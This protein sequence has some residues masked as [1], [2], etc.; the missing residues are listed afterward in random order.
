MTPGNELQVGT[1]IGK[2]GERILR[3]ISTEKPKSET[4]KICHM[5]M[6]HTDD[7]GETPNMKD[8]K[9]ILENKPQEKRCDQMG[10]KRP[11]SL[12]KAVSLLRQYYNGKQEGG[13]KIPKMVEQSAGG[14]EVNLKTAV[15]LLRQYYNNKYKQ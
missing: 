3:I 12:E 10:G 14:K 13:G 2:D 6:T 15:H 11:V 9:K 5:Y 8:F 4:C 1:I 7:S